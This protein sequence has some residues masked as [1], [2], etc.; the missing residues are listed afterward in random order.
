M[1]DDVVHPGGGE[2]RLHAEV[3]NL[4][5]SGM[6]QATRD[7][8]A[9]LR[10]DRR[11]FV[12]SRAGFA[13]LQRHAMQ[14]TGDNSSWWEHLWMSLPQLQN[15]GL[16]GM[17][18]CGV[19]CGG[20]FGDAD[21]EL[22][23]RWVEAGIFQPFLR[24]H[25][26]MDSTRQEPWAFGEPW[27]SLIRD[28]L[29]LRMRLLPYLYGVFEEASRT[30][31]PVLRPLL[32]EF[33]DDPVTYTAD[34]EFM[35]GD[36]LL[37]APVTRPGIEHRHVYLPAGAWVHWWTG[38][39]FEGPAH[40]LAHA[41]LGRPALYARGNAAI[42]LGNE[43]MHVGEPLTRLTLRVFAAGAEP[44]T[45]VVYEDAGEGFGPSLR[46]E[47]TVDGASV[48]VTAPAGEYE[49]PPRVVEVEVVRGGDASV[50]EIGEGAAEITLR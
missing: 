41:P 40:V 50:T 6:A 37:V 10:P 46:R 22:L 30:G 9:R 19:D 32:F 14:W 47:V 33:P 8:L 23:A 16:S 35:L 4:Y 13:G 24:N 2:A 27:E 11:P 42:P 7:G 12:I 20:F 1:P 28:S 31:A 38:E 43:R 29:L 48:R 25:A 49:P 34:D 5:G 15:L 18:F 26:H 44:V 39:V 3:H 17:A 36:A 45:R 21:G